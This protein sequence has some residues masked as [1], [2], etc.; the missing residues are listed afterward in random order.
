VFLVVSM[1]LRD[2]GQGTSQREGGTFE[3]LWVCMGGGLVIRTARHGN[4]KA[5][6]EGL[7]WYPLGLAE[8]PGAREVRE[9]GPWME[10]ANCRKWCP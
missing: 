1:L 3:A 8:G 6:R 10:A 7:Q 9:A 2:R 5:R 4:E